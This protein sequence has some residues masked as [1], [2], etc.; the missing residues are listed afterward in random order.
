MYCPKCMKE[1]NTKREDLDWFLLIILAVFTAGFGVIIYLFIYF[2]KPENRCMHCNS[3]CEPAK[4]IQVNNSNYQKPIS[5][6]SNPYQVKEDS[7]NSNKPSEDKDKSESQLNYCP[8]CGS[9]LSERLEVNFC[10]YCG[11]SL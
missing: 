5:S 11:F 1:V 8:S 9:K 3:I 2:D 7:S 6:T 10:P 4:F